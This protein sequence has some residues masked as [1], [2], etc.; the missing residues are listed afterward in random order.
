MLKMLYGKV[1]LLSDTTVSRDVREVHGISKGQVAKVLQV[2]GNT[3]LIYRYLPLDIRH[4][5]GVSMS[6]STD[7]H[8]QMLSRSL[9]L[10][11][12]MLMKEN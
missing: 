3:L 11:S 2:G 7:G 6:V 8:R 10:S 5:P 9:E 1:E 4:I 12:T